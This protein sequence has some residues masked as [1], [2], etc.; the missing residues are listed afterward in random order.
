MKK[1]SLVLA[2]MVF[3]MANVD[4]QKS[5]RTS[6]LNYLK[7]GKLDKAKEFIDIAANHPKT[8]AEA[9]TWSYR[10]NIYVSI[11]TDSTEKYA[12]LR[13]NAVDEAIRSY[14]KVMILDEK[15]I[16]KIE[17]EQKI[18]ALTD[19]LFND[20]A[21]AL[22]NSYKV[23]D[24][25]ERVAS[26]VDA[27][28]MLD[29]CYRLYSSAGRLDTTALYYIGLANQNAFRIKK[30]KEVY[31]ELISMNFNKPDVYIN[32]GNIYADE[33]NYSEAIKY[34]DMGSKRYPNNLD[35]VLNAS[36]VYIK[37]NDPTKAIAVLE[38]AASLDPNNP[39]VYFAIGSK[40]D[41]VAKDTTKT[42]ADR[43]VLLDKAL[44]A[45]SK[46]IEI[47]PDYLDA[48]YNIGVMFV[49]QAVEAK[50]KAD[51]LPF[52]EQKKYDKLNGEAD[53]LLA[54]ALPYMERAHELDSTDRA[55]MSSLKEIYARLKNYDKMKEMQAKLNK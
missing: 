27:A 52:S 41:E 16:Y 9:K 35:I 45:Y 40:Y 18:L 29:K 51:A 5:K 54:K 33:G 4:A 49:N 7:K 17:A 8:G 43:K 21:N 10:G 53:A 6:A 22:R 55:V 13:K 47:K 28:D 23:T 42:D 50:T 48:T 37:D 26:F 39:S 31:D 36:N 24:S 2:L 46:A 34:F 19:F 12:P 25:A 14:Q 11:L 38:K 15:G 30:A 1:L 32:M 3:I 44:E 20:A